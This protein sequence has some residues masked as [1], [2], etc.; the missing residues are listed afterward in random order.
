MRELIMRRTKLKLP[1]L[2]VTLLVSWTLVCAS[3]FIYWIPSDL[4]AP[5][6]LQRTGGGLGMAILFITA[7]GLDAVIPGSMSDL[8]DLAYAPVL[9]TPAA[10]CLNLVL[11]SVPAFAIVGVFGN[12]FPNVASFL[13]FAWLVFYLLLFL[14]LAP[15]AVR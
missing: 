8:D 6:G 5:I 4:L 13:V 9:F 14:V 3:T 10:M 2:K 1:S 11:F 15:N 7:S 12:R